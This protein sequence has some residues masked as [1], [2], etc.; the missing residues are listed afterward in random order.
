MALTKCGDTRRDILTN[1]RRTRYAVQSSGYAFSPEA[2][3]RP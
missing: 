3:V 1:P 2:F